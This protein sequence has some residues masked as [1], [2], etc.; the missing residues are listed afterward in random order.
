MPLREDF[1]SDADELA[2]ELEAERLAQEAEAQRQAAA[3]QKAREDLIDRTA[4]AWQDLNTILVNGSSRLEN[5]DDPIGTLEYVLVELEALPVPHIDPE[6][7]ALTQ[8]IYR[9]LY[10]A[11]QLELNYQA[12]MEELGVN[13]VEAG[14][15]GCDFARASVEENQWGWCLG[16]GLLTGTLMAADASEEIK[17]LEAEYNDRTAALTAE[18]AAFPERMEAMEAY[19]LEEYGITAY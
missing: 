17:Q 3:A 4:E 8:D 15:M 18:I 9:V 5:S 1:Y 19:L 10:D 2:D 11:H 6:L 14:Q 12:R 16:A 13:I 7:A